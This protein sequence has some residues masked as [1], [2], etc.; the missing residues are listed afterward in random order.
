MINQKWKKIISKINFDLQAI[1]NIK[2]GQTYGVEVLLR[3]VTKAGAFYS[4]ANLFDEA[5]NDG[6]L[7]KVDLYLRLIALKKFKKIDIKNLRMFYN[8]DHRIMNM[9]D[10]TAGNTE[11]L[12]EKL[13]ISK[14]TIYFEISEKSSLKDPSYVRN[15]SSRY[16]QEGYNVVIDNFATGVSGIQLLFYPNCDFIKLDRMF[17]QDIA[18][19]TKKRLFFHSIINMAHIMNIKVIASCVETINEYYVCKDLGVDFIQGFFIQKPVSDTA[20]IAASY[21]EI[22]EL[23]KNDKRDVNINVIDKEKIEK[24]ASLNI[25]ATLEDL[26]NYFKQNPE[27]HF[28]PIVDEF[29]NLLGAVYEKDIKKMSYSQYGMSLAKNTNMELGVETFIKNIVSAEIT[30]NVDKILDIYNATTFDKSGIFITKNNQ[31]FGFVTVNNLLELSY[32]RNI[33]IARDQ[34]PLTKLAGNTQIER[35][36]EKALTSSV[37]F[38]IVY[39]DFNDFKPFNDYYGFRQGD[40]AILMFSE[41]IKKQLFKEKIFIGHIGGDDFFAGFEGYDFFDVYTM[42][43]KVQKDFELQVSSLYNQK[44]RENHFIKTKDRFGNVRNFNLLGVA[45]AILEIEDD[46]TKTDFDE[47]LNVAKKSAKNTNDP[48]GLSIIKG[49]NIC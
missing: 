14:K 33:E 37:Q 1:V 46:I 27:N 31:Y 48:V 47:I 2:S 32:Y 29:H 9:P 11:K 6:V 26:F 13:S 20:K 4:I 40:R 45:T 5:Y 43:N 12:S 35:F 30:W 44:D 36:I 28:S 8:I 25:N 10:F 49:N 42:V 16:K 18:K 38:H 19:D 39:F 22:K 7:Y 21:K 23:Y 3:D 34:N 15:L 17:I 24:L 41:I